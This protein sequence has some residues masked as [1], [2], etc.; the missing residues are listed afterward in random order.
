VKIAEQRWHVKPSTFVKVPA[1][2]QHS[3]TNTGTADL[4]F[5]VIYDPPSFI[6]DPPLNDDGT[7]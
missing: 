7:P 3:V 5:L 6:Y 4:I 1:S 2:K